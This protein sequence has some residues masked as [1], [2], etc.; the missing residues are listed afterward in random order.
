MPRGLTAS[1]GGTWG[2]SATH[3]RDATAAGEAG[4]LIG[5]LLA[6]AVRLTGAWLI[7]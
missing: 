3:Y 7:N 6:T 5:C 2:I 1:L 4:L